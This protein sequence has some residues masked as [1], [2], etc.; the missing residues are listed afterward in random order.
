MFLTLS[1]FHALRMP[2][3]ENLISEIHQKKGTWKWAVRITDMWF[4]QKGGGNSEVHMML[5]DHTIK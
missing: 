4:V 1:V 3:K 2:L 5:M